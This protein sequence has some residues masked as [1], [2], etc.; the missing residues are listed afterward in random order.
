MAAACAM[1]LF[2]AGAL[3]FRSSQPSPDPGEGRWVQAAEEL[4]DYDVTLKL[5]PDSREI[6]ITERIAFRNC[7]GEALRDLVLRTWLNAFQSEDTSPAAAEE[8]YDACYPDGF[9]PGYLTIHDVQWNGEQRPYAFNDAAQTVLRVDIPPLPDGEAGEMTLRCVAKIPV[10]AHRTGVVDQTYQLGNVIPQV[11]LY[12]AHAWRTDEY[13]PIGDPFVSPCAN[14]SVRV[15]LP[16]EYVPACSAALERNADGSWYGKIQAARDV[17]LCVSPNYVMASGRAGNTPVYAYALSREGARRAME[18]ARKA[19]ETFTSLYGDFP[20]PSLSVCSVD[21]PF[22]GMEYS[23][24]VMIGQ[25]YFLDTWK[26]TLELTV[27]HETAHQ[28][29]YGLVGSDQVNAPWQDEALCQYAMLRYV[30]ARYGQSSFDS[31]KY[32]QVDAPMMERIPGSLTPGSPIDYFGSLT[33]YSAI[34]Y[35]RGAALLLALEEMLPQG[36]DAFLA[37]Y[38]DRFAYQFVSR[39]EFESFLNT[40]AGADCSPLLLDYLD[41]A[42]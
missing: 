38:A 32:Y 14:Y 3:I 22:G 17:A 28:W 39:A 27:A 10:C 34:V 23:G 1:L 16:E 26:D 7:T 31:L 24:L 30:R 33:D 37:A 18:D 20:Y 40:W 13:V 19:I 35:G 12:Q 42:H 5:L 21:F 6:S 29:F 8:L 9:S 36:I 41:T 25:T 11:P 4:T 2:V 15:Y